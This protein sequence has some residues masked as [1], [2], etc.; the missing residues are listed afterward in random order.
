[1]G[2]GLILTNHHVFGTREDA[3]G[4]GAQFLYER[5]REGRLRSGEIFPF[6]PARFFVTDAELDYAIVAIGARSLED[7]DLDA[8][9]FLPLI[10]AKGKILKGDPVNIIQYPD[11]GPKMYATVNN[12]LIELRDDGTLLYDT[13]T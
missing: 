2:P 9:Q 6:E 3:A 11:G 5:E 7:T 10:E 4:L 8:F 1:I 12:H 13:D